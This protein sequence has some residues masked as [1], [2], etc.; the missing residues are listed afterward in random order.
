[1]RARPCLCFQLGANPGTRL[2]LS[3]SP[4]DSPGCCIGWV[5]ADLPIA[6]GSA[7]PAPISRIDT[8]N[9]SLLT[10]E[11]RLIGDPDGSVFVR[12]TVLCCLLMLFLA[13]FHVGGFPLID[14][15]KNPRE[16][17]SSSASICCW[18]VLC[19]DSICC[20]RSLSASRSSVIVSKCL[21]SSFSR[22]SRWA[23]SFVAM[24]SC[25]A[26]VRDGPLV[27]ADG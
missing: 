11:M 13:L 10:P 24:V 23:R 9:S 3:N 25:W 27:L 21:L 18:C 16:S 19:V 15:R 14:F 17:E 7:M 1:M 6:N 8:T 20:A 22:S 5:S 4:V 26:R 12:S 2:L